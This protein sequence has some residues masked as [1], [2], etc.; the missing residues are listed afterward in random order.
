M[1]PL[2]AQAGVGMSGLSLGGS[3]MV[4]S[5]G[6]GGMGVGTMGIGMGGLNMGGM[7]V[8]LPSIGAGM[9]GIGMGGMGQ[10]NGLSNVIM[11]TNLPLALEETQVKELVGTFGEVKAFNLI[12]SAGLSQSAVLEYTNNSV[13][14]EAI[15]GLN[16]LEIADFKLAVQRVPIE[17]AAIL[18]QPSSTSVNAA[19]ATAAALT[20]LLT[21][22]SNQSQS[23]PTIPLID[24][25]ADPLTTLTPT[26]ILRLSNMTMPEDLTDDEA[27]SELQ[28]DVLEECS[29]YGQIVSIEIPRPVQAGGDPGMYNSN[30]NSIHIYVKIIHAYT[31]YV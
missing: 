17:S 5:M 18:L 13:T 15:L 3:A 14:D 28:E 31:V 19:T 29:K 26:R 12:K 11:V 24:P 30:Y 9:G 21:N 27:Y 23:S 25:T 7:G 6:V 22:Q 20:N 16:K 8:G 2:L 10:V 4:P 1:N